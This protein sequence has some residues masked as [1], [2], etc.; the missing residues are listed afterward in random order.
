MLQ[1]IK[2]SMVGILNTVI[3]IISYNILTFTGINYILSNTIAYILGMIN[4]YFWNKTWVFSSKDK[5]I[6]LVIK[7]IIVN[8][9][10]LVLNNYI[11]HVFVSNFKFNKSISQIPAIICGMVVNFV[12]NKIWTFKD[13]GGK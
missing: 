12:L 11:L 6:N 2:F 7:F 9:I 10:T 8:F 3:T 5:D 4:S 13:K 1:F